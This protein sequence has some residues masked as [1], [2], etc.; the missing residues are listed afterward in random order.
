MVFLVFIDTFTGPGGAPSGGSRITIHPWV[1]HEGLLLPRFL[2]AAASVDLGVTESRKV[3]PDTTVLVTPGGVE[4]GFIRSPEEA[5]SF[6]RLA[7]LS[8][9]GGAA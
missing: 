4:L 5:S 7:W 9:S 6:G 2:E 1:I 8:Q 3:V